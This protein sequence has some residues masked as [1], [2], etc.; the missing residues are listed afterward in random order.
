MKASDPAGRKPS[1]TGH[2]S[3]IGSGT[4]FPMKFASASLQWRSTNQNSA[5]AS[6]HKDQVHRHD[7]LLRL[8]IIG[9]SDLEGP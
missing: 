8:G 1:K 3:Q 7:Q 9:L 6:W 4:A 5:H 2:R